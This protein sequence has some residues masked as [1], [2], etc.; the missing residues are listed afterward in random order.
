MRGYCLLFMSHSANNVERIFIPINDG[1]AH[2]FLLIISL[3]KENL[4]Y[5]DY[6]YGDATQ[7]ARHD[8]L[9]RMVSGAEFIIY[10]AL[11]SYV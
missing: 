9:I 2:W 1:N 10:L 6:D 11:Y 3:S 8:L 4:I 7:I 5:L